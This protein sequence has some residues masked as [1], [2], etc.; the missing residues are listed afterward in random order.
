MKLEFSTHIFEQSSN[1]NFHENPSSGNQVIPRG[2]TDMK[3]LTVAF[4]NVAYA[5]KNT[6]QKESDVRVSADLTF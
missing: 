6:K 3:K 5:P 2:R 4:R 1:I